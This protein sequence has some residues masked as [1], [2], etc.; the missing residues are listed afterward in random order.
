LHPL[1]KRRLVTAHVEN[2]TLDGQTRID[3]V[4]RE[5]AIPRPSEVRAIGLIRRR[6]A[7]YRGDG[8]IH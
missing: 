1:E 7:A 3:A 5:P 6:I 8:L 2:L 4:A